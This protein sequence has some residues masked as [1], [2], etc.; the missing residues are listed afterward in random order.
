MLTFQ[1]LVVGRDIPSAASSSGLLGTANQGVFRTFSPREKCD[2]GSALG[3]GTGC[4]HPLIH[5]GGSA[6]G[7]LRGRSWCVDAVSRWLV[8]TSGLGPTSLAA[9]KKAGTGPSSCVSLR[10]LLEAFPVLFARAVRTWNLEH[11]FRVPV[12]GSLCSGRLGV[13]YDCENWIFREMTF[14]V[15]AMLGTTVD[16]CSA[17]VFWRLWMNFTHFLFCCRLES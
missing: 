6:G 15:E 11:Y 17:S 2:V 5:A 10:M 3:V 12:S 14:F 13:A 4:G 8:E 7:F 9:W 16:T 1:F